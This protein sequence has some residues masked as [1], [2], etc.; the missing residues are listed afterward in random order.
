MTSLPYDKIPMPEVGTPEWHELRRINGIG[1]SEA[2]TALGLSEWM[3]P[4]ELHA[5][6]CGVLLPNESNRAMR[7]GSGMES[8]ICDE[9]Q[10][11]TGMKGTKPDFMAKST[12]YPWLFAD[13]DFLSED[14]TEAAEIKRS[15]APDKWGEAGTDE[16]PLNY[17]IQCQQTLVVSKAKVIHLAV[18]LPYDELRIYPI[19][20]EAEIQ[21]RI[22]KGTADFWKLVQAGTPPPMD[23]S[24]PKALETVK[25]RYPTAEDKCV[26]LHDAVSLT[27]ARFVET[28]ERIKALEAEKDGLEAL[29]LDQI[30]DAAAAEIKGRYALKRTKVSK[31]PYTVN[32]KPYYTLKIKEIA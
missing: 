32:P 13:M 16:V 17:F 19:T 15:N 7:L 27:V 5:L 30:G 3:T 29:I 28:K 4:V 8:M 11:E 10:R 1:A 20:P 24:H 9:F 12:E 26:V 2:A 23:Y 25:H 21:E 31:K 6:K 18:L 14:G 22:I